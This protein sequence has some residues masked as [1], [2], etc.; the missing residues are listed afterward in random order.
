MHDLTRST[1]EINR[2]YCELVRNKRE[3]DIR[4]L[5]EY[6]RKVEYLFAEA[7]RFGFE[8]AF[9]KRVWRIDLTETAH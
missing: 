7:E 3:E 6:L 1:R 2:Y 8:A 4:I 9:S 5:R